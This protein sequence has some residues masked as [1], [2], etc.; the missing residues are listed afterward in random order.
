M[1][2]KKNRRQH[3]S[4]V[5]DSA[6]DLEGGEEQPFVI[7]LKK[8]DGTVWVFKSLDTPIGVCGLGHW[9]AN[10]SVVSDNAEP[11]EASVGFTVLRGEGVRLDE[12][13]AFLSRSD[14]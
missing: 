1:D 13:T 7:Y 11:L 10:I 2:H 6:V 4:K 8:I 14:G 5:Y 12:P 3:G 9:T